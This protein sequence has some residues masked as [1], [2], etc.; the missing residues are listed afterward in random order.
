M[1]SDFET[2]KEHARKNLFMLQQDNYYKNLHQFFNWLSNVKE[3]FQEDS[4]IKPVRKR[5]WTSPRIKLNS[6]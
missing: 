6:Q 2:F 4:D 5:I 1:V 3:G